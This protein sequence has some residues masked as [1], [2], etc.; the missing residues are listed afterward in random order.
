MRE[1]FICIVANALLHG[2][3]LKKLPKKIACLLIW[4]G[5][6]KILVTKKYWLMD[7]IYLFLE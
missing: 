6:Q 7:G 3:Q 1:N 2:I 5:I 4:M